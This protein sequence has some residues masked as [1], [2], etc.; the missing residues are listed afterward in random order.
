MNRWGVSLF[1]CSVLLFGCQLVKEQSAVR[2][3]RS[4]PLDTTV[5]VEE[6]PLEE[7]GSSHA[8]VRM[9]DKVIAYGG[10]GMVGIYR[11][12]G[13]H[14]LYK[15][16]LEHDVFFLENNNYCGVTNGV[17]EVFAWKGDSLER[18]SSFTLYKGMPRTTVESLGD[19]NYVFADN[20]ERRG[21]KE[22]HLVNS[23]TQE[24][25]SKGSYPEDPKRFK[26]IKD[27][28]LAYGHS[29]CAKP[30]KSRFVLYYSLNR[31]FRI[32]DQRGELLHDVF[33][34]YPPA[35]NKVVDSSYERQYI[36]FSGAYTTEKY[37]YLLSP[38][39]RGLGETKPE[40]AILVV[41]WEG[42]LVARY[43]LNAYL[44]SFF[45]DEVSR[46]CMGV[47]YQSGGAYRF[48]SFNY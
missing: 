1:F 23:R 47:G 48:F 31:R 41:D 38:D 9:G 26:H 43:R 16:S 29:L 28:K 13:M 2:Y 34:D 5:C 14:F 15:R 3:C 4:F 25:I 30:D 8:L 21:L 35:N 45:V 11:Y 7:L 22:F 18:T 36:H 20:Y 46:K 12:P 39:T 19:G 27:F 42:N 24:C 37:I 40:C 10:Y 17:A 6:T 44:Y 33:L 32:Y